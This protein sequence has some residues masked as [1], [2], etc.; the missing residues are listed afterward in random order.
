MIKID[1][2]VVCFFLKHFLIHII[3][4]QFH[5]HR[6][7][8][9]LKISLC[10]KSSMFNN[11]KIVNR[12]SFFG[13]VLPVLAIS[14][15]H[16]EEF[17][18][19]SDFAIE[20]IVVTSRFLEEN[21]QDSPQA[22]TAFSPDVLQKLVAQD[23]RDIS[24][25]TPNLM[26]EPVTTF[27]N[28]AS[29]RLRGIGDIRIESTEENLTGI[30]MD[31]VFITR[32]V[33]TLFDFFDVERI[34]V[35]RGPQGTA[36]G[37]NS[38][39]GGI[40][41]TSAK[42]TDE[43]GGKAELTF[44]NY[45]RSDTRAVV[46]VPMT[47]TLSTRLAILDQN[48][49]GHYE[50]RVNGKDLGK[51]ELFT[52]RGSLLYTPNDGV[53]V[54]LRTWYVHDR[55]GAPGGDAGTTSPDQFLMRFTP[56]DIQ[57]EDA[58]GPYTVGRDWVDDHHTNQHGYSAQVDARIG[59]IDVVSITGYIETE[60]EISSDYDQTEYLFF[61][62]F[63]DQRHKQF[64]QEL[65]LRPDF[66]GR[67]DQWASLDLTMGLFYM[68]QDH[69]ITQTYPTQPG[70][71]WD[72]S[73]PLWSLCGGTFDPTADVGCYSADYTKQKSTSWGVFAQAIYPITDKLNLTVGSRYSDE[74]KHFHRNPNAFLAPYPVPYSFSQSPHYEDLR[75]SVSGNNDAALKGDLD[76]NHITWMSS[77]DYELDDTSM[78]YVKYAQGFKGGQFAARVSTPV[79]AEPTDDNTS[80][81]YELGY[82]GSFLE[83]HL[84]LN[85][86][87]YYAIYSDLEVSTFIPSA[88][89]V[90]G[91]ETIVQNIGKRESKGIELEMNYLVNERFSWVS[92]V[93]YMKT[94][95][96]EYCID[97][98]GPQPDAG[99]PPVSSCGNS[100]Q[101]DNGSWLVDEDL[102]GE[103]DETDPR[104]Q[105]YNRFQ[106]DIILNEYGVVS[107]IGSAH[108]LSKYKVGSDGDVEVKARIT[109]DANL[110]W[111][112]ASERYRVSLW[113]KN[114]TDE[115]YVV[116]DINVAPFFH[117]RYWST[118]LQWGVDITANF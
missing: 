65:R 84:Q 85:A 108:Y 47:E 59:S 37:K 82:K 76:S 80:D 111:T 117:Q 106:Y 94:Q 110:S 87:L 41:V 49:D 115:Q 95:H 38:L 17:I 12:L 112:S 27:P 62:S 71:V 33:A 4:F 50:N 22:V 66:S 34:E 26:I 52:A 92:N 102:S 3:K 68:K 44:G 7:E 70:R 13:V 118:P 79:A 103:F 19:D 54:L 60:D 86:A 53:E 30:S 23:L 16:S 35:L 40:V 21:I 81:S 43:L 36:F 58:D 89:N 2:L 74:E 72:P 77:L 28:S 56:Y 98:N 105:I 39:A 32:P 24:S 8:V 63:R 113:G 10:W 46:N 5:I 75:G 90:T 69:E 6:S 64:S 18:G 114:L 1:E 31:G 20:E 96:L 100:V 14:S 57:A 9:V 97:R 83:G 29:V 107:V 93:G 104:W 51:E 25:S 55:S 101:L 116:N 67:S 48:Y 78:A 61:P 88:T 91:G 11:K 45:G 42:P 99:S 109:V 73:S 15:V